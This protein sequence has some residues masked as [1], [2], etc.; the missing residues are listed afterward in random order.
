MI[1]I[2]LVG[3]W[4]FAAIV[5]SFYYEADNVEKNTVPFKPKQVDTFESLIKENFTIY[6]TNMGE[7][8]FRSNMSTGLDAASVFG[9]LF[10]VS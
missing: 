1:S 10:L 4:L 8:K 5:I 9:L 2:I 6:T 7:D 3:A